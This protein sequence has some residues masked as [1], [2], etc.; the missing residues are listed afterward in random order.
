MKY[1]AVSNFWLEKFNLKGKQVI[2]KS[3]YDAFSN[4]DEERR[5]RHKRILTGA[6]EKTNE[7][8]FHLEGV[9]EP[10]FISWEMRPWYQYD[11]TIGGMMIS[12]QDITLSVKHREEL[13]AAK[14]LAEQASNAKS[15]FLASMSHEIRTPLNGVIGFTDLLL[16][17]R[18]NET[19]QQYLNIVNHSANALLSIINDILD[20]SKIEAGKLELDIEKCDIYEL[21]SQATDIITYQ[22]QTKG[23]EMLLNVSPDLPRFIWADA[24]RLKQILIN[25]LGN[26]TKFTET[27]E[28]E[29]KIEVLSAYNDHTRIRFAVRDTGIG[30][31]PEQ[32]SKIFQAFSQE[33]PS[34]TKK[35]GG[36]G[37]G[38]T[39]SNRLL[40]LMDSGLK[41]ESTPGIG[42]TFYFDLDLKSA[43][44]EP[45]SWEN[46]ELI[47][48]ALI[49]DDNE[50]NRLILTQMLLLKNIESVNAG[51]GQEALRLLAKGEQFDVIIM[52][53]H[54]PQMDGLEVIK[55]IREAF[56]N[57]GQI[58]VI[59]LY[60][61]SDDGEII[62]ACDALQV[63]HRL[64]KPVK[65]QDVYHTLSRLHV[66]ETDFAAGKVVDKITTITARINIL[67]AE[68]NAVNM[69]LAKTI[70]K[71]IAPN[72]HIMEAKTGVEA[73]EMCRRLWPDL[74]FM[75]IQ[76]PEMNGYDT[77]RQIRAMQGE[78]HIPVIAL[79][80]GNVKG[81]KEKCLAAGMDDFLVK[82]IVEDSLG[83]MF[84]KWI[85]HGDQ[86]V[87][88]TL[89]HFDSNTIRSYV[90]DDI[91]TINEII[92]LT[93]IEL[94]ESLITLT[95]HIKNKDLKALNLTGHKL[96][97]TAI[98][99]G[100]PAL[101][102]IAHQYEHMS[103]FSAQCSEELLLK[104][105]REITIIMDIIE[106]P[107]TY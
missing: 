67:V 81:E 52:D 89:V 73:L 53:Y 107:F 42:S 56:Q 93:K 7:D 26:A 101:A 55:K 91:D 38:L 65:M 40:E 36:T 68:D 103:E 13:K 84:N 32:Q 62:K 71:R 39:I 50:N 6:V 27:G 94:A 48:R 100:L 2:G 70:L 30:I 61:S 35:Y 63:K 17:T 57:S 24:L 41:L 22:V 97:G 37:L 16:K 9:E 34:T 11:G 29:L 76:M 79:T 102:E 80:A 21:G 82:P 95:A 45:V 69:L 74:V 75:D 99:A 23:L 1:V 88:D 25:L 5:E 8:I 46:I 83:L 60:S 43:Q 86:A 49:V 44:G 104:T 77:T 66:K 31:K 64:V 78:K 59:L 18:L 14:L 33:D 51:N 28:I 10:M 58:P 72:A 105:T 85:N 12:I 96:Y 90:G 54:M 15:E 4:L 87:N 92:G 47:K 98:S 3:Y 20:F 19:Q 106:A